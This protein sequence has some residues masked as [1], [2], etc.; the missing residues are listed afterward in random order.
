[1][2][3]IHTFGAECNWNAHI[4]FLVTAGWVNI[5]N[6]DERINVKDKYLP[7]R[8]INKK[9]KYNLL[10]NLRQYGKKL[11][12][13]DHYKEFN[14]LI[15]FLFRQRDKKDPKKEKSR[16]VYI[17]K[18]I[19][20]FTWAVKYIWR[21]LKRPIIWESRIEK[22]DW[23]N[24]TFSFKHRWTKQK[25]IKTISDFDFFC[26]LIRHI[27]DDHFKMVWY[28]GIFANRIKKKYLAKMDLYYEQIE[29]Q[30]YGILDNDKYFEDPN[31]IDNKPF[32]KNF[33][34]K[35]GGRF[36]AYKI[37]FVNYGFGYR[38]EIFFDSS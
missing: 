30:K 20:T 2:C 37:T 7:Y 16:F 21:Y 18:K 14:K 11:F 19:K 26:E 22:Y 6:D 24:V 1:M 4:H 8:L 35:C 12:S 34:C 17:D 36:V 15:D 28:G 32:Y 29:V 27:P 5:D 31:I 23:E 33:K 10:T 38:Q 13:E 25:V 3:V 9:W